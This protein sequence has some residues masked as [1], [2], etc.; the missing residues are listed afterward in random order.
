MKIAVAG[1]KGGTG[2]TLVATNIFYVLM[3]EGQQVELI[4]CDAEEPNDTLFFKGEIMHHNDVLLKVPE[5][6]TS[7][8]V[9]CGKCKEYCN[10]N[11]ILMIGFSNYIK[12]IEELCHGCGACTVA[13]SYGAIREIDRLIGEVNQY[14]I[15]QHALLTEARMRVGVYSPVNTVKAALKLNPE[16]YMQIIDAPPGTSCPFIHSVVHADYVILVTEPTPFGLS[17][18]KQT[19][20]T[21]KGMNKRYG[22][23]INRVDVP[24][25]E[26]TDYLKKENIPLLAEIPFDRRIA[27]VYAKGGLCAQQIPAYKHQFKKIVHFINQEICK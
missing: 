13:C 20:E 3:E 22:V 23:I 24:N 21:L 19:V 16:P 15:S 12:V 5:I 9:F 25:N 14:R 7:L 17:D 18:L 27:E 8:C 10:Y 6:D 1:G 2:K 11:A 26:M 4:D